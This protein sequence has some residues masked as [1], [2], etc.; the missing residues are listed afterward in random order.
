MG[1]FSNLFGGDDDL[2]ARMRAEAK[3]GLEDVAK[4][5]RSYEQEAQTDRDAIRAAAALRNGAKIK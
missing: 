2:A 1:W 4:I 3:Q 5:G